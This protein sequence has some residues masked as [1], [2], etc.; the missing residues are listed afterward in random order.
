MTIHTLHTRLPLLSQAIA[1][2]CDDVARTHPEA[3]ETVKVTNAAFRE[4]KI[5]QIESGWNR[6]RE[7]KQ[8]TDVEHARRMV[9]H[10]PFGYTPELIKVLS[11]G[12]KSPP[13]HREIAREIRFPYNLY[14]TSRS[15]WFR[16]FAHT[17]TNQLGEEFTTENP[18]GKMQREFEHLWP[19]AKHLSALELQLLETFKQ[20]PQIAQKLLQ[21]PGEKPTAPKNLPADQLAKSFER[22][23][24]DLIQSGKLQQVSKPSNMYVV[25]IFF[26][27]ARYS[28]KEKRFAK[29]LLIANEKKKNLVT[30][31]V[32]AH[33]Y[34]VQHRDLANV[35][36]LAML[37][38]F[39][40][41]TNMFTACSKQLIKYSLQHASREKV[42]DWKNLQ[43]TFSPN[44]PVKPP[45][46][47]KG[48][49]VC[50]LGKVDLSNAFYQLPARDPE[51]YII[52]VTDPYKTG[53]EAT[54]LYR[55]LVS[56][57]GNRHS[58]INFQCNSCFLAKLLWE[59]F[60]I[61]TEAFMDD[62]IVLSTVGTEDLA[63]ET[64]KQVLR[65]LGYQVTI[66]PGGCIK[67]GPG[68][69]IEILGVDYLI[70]PED[71]T[72]KTFLPKNKRETIIGEAEDMV[73]ELQKEN[74]RIEQARFL[75]LAG[76]VN[77]VV[78]HRRHFVESPLLAVLQP[79]IDMANY[80]PLTPL[81]ICEHDTQMLRKLLPVLIEETKSSD[82]LYTT[83][84]G[85][86]Q[87]E[88][89]LLFTDAAKDSGQV[90][91]GWSR[92]KLEPNTI[93]CIEAAGTT[94]ENKEAPALLRC[95]NIMEWE[96]YAVYNALKAN[97]HTIR[98]KRI[99]LNVD[100]SGAAFT[101]R[102][103]RAKTTLGLAIT[104]AIRKFAADAGADLVILYVN[105]ARN[106]S[107]LPSRKDDF[108]NDLGGKKREFKWA[109]KDVVTSFRLLNS[110]SKKG[111]K[112]LVLL[113]N[114]Q[115]ASVAFNNYIDNNLEYVNYSDSLNLQLSQCQGVGEKLVE[116]NPLE[117]Q[118][119]R[120]R[121]AE[122]KPPS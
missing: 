99:I 5:K 82:W 54:K 4:M 8:K 115:D 109:L 73:R 31:P 44:I 50:V 122:K 45:T 52:A 9:E 58:P 111:A 26:A 46:W 49:F 107:D 16:G 79:Y 95:A 36:A 3:S 61:A 118:P 81:K 18:N 59:F 62:F 48:A 100:N 76:L 114:Q 29:V 90:G 32:S 43:N 101:L 30:S 20:N 92:H 11:D 22:W 88:F 77:F 21:T 40:E 57:F 83:G 12:P 1:K 39:G 24:T 42:V 7:L 15:G 10:R 6:L 85:D 103:N 47:K 117:N 33:L 13:L 2:T 121:R 71:L 66:K 14:S 37:G 19:A 25:P 68:E 97:E 93:E 86:I 112:E 70:N 72:I 87:K 60:G 108:I 89:I 105:T 28:F 84:L 53:A 23:E 106:P 96:L 104:M 64:T 17:G 110:V 116:Q 27:G 78:M 55:S 56:T 34:M 98:N 74:P 38:N 63:F 94:A 67:P 102:K 80:D 65:F 41:E 69:R 35:L 113:P 119:K 75:R 120:R 51:K 91:V